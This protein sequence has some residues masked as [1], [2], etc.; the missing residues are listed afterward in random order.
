MNKVKR[1]ALFASASEK[2]GEEYRL[3]AQEL[4]VCLAQAGIA[5]VYG[6]GNQGL[7]QACAAAVL[8]QRGQ[9]EAVLWSRFS[10]NINMVTA[11]D[12]QL[13]MHYT[14]SLSVRKERLRQLSDAIVVLPGGFG[15]LDELV[16]TLEY[17]L[18]G[19]FTKPIILLNI[20]HFYDPLLAF[21]NQ[22]LQQRM[23]LVQDYQPISS[24]ELLYQVANTPAE[25]I[26]FLQGEV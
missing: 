6:G 11:P 16:E 7:M 5:L 25:V 19:D 21:F 26:N 13:I 17:K 24:L 12:S 3:A 2:I 9:V 8:Q 4:G 15:T 22:L 20:N 23:V 1:I 18:L 14:E 10:D